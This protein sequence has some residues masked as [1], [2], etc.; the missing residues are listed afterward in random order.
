[1]FNER[2]RTQS[3]IEHSRRAGAV[4]ARRAVDLRRPVPSR[5][6]ELSTRGMTRCGV[7]DMACPG[8]CADGL[9]VCGSARGG[10]LSP[11]WA[12]EPLIAHSVKT[13]A[14]DEVSAV[15]SASVPVSRRLRSG[16][17]RDPTTTASASRRRAQVWCSTVHPR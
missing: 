7:S 6:P 1:V 3:R 14:G 8:A 12:V 13:P 4:G 5:H 10:G 17:D 9:I 2:N 16:D 15:V 11:R